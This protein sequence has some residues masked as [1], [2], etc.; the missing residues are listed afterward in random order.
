[1]RFATVKEWLVHSRKKPRTKERK[2]RHA[3]FRFSI[4]LQI[5]EQVFGAKMFV[6]SLDSGRCSQVTWTRSTFFKNAKR[7]VARSTSSNSP[8]IKSTSAFT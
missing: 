1:M 8:V 3:E 2:K 5:C 6:N 7:P 4:S